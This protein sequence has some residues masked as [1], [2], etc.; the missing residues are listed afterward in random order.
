[1]PALTEVL[2]ARLRGLGMH[3]E[4]ETL[5]RAVALVRRHSESPS[6]LEDVS[7]MT[8]AV[9]AYRHPERDLKEIV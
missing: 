6:A 5:A 7:L 1:M 2:R 8:I 9:E 3:F 4:D